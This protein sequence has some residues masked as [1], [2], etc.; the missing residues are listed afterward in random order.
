MSIPP[1]ALHLPHLKPL[2]S[3]WQFQ[4]GQP[5]GGAH[6]RWAGREAANHFYGLAPMDE[7]F[8]LAFPGLTATKVDATGFEYYKSTLK[9]VP[10]GPGVLE[11]E[12]YKPLQLALSAICRG[13]RGEGSLE[14]SIGADNMINFLDEGLKLSPD[15]IFHTTYTRS[16]PS[17][18]YG[19]S[20][21]EV[22][23]DEN[24]DPLHLT[25]R[26]AS[27]RNVDVWNQ[28]TE[29][30]GI[31]QKMTSRCFY[32]AAGV[33]GEKARFFLWDRSGV[34]AS[35]S[36]KYKSNP[37]PL[38]KFL[39]G[40]ANYRTGGLDATALHQLDTT[41]A[42]N[43]CM[44]W[45][46]I[47]E[48]GLLKGRDYPAATLS[49]DLPSESSIVLV[50]G[51]D[52]SKQER[53]LTIGRPVFASESNFGRGTRVWLAIRAE[54]PTDE[55]VII[56]DGWRD[57]GRWS[58][59]RIYDYI[60]KKLGEIPGIARHKNGFDVDEQG[61][62]HRTLAHRLVDAL[63]IGPSQH[64]IHHRCIL[65]SVGKPL[66]SFSSTYQ[67]L[68]AIRDVVK[69]LHDLAKLGILHR[70]IS[71]NNIMISIDPV[72]ENGAKG[73]VID[74]ELA[75]IPEMSKK[76]L[77]YLTGTIQFLSIERLQEN[78]SDHKSWHDLE[79]VFWTVLWTVL[80]H[81]NSWVTITEYGTPRPG[82]DCVTEIFD[83]PKGG[84]KMI[85]LTLGKVEVQAA[86]SVYTKYIRD[87]EI[88]A[89]LRQEA[90]KE[91]KDRLSHESF[92]KAI[93]DALEDRS[94]WPSN[95]GAKNFKPAGR[96][97]TEDNTETGI[98]LSQRASWYTSSRDRTRP[99]SIDPPRSMGMS[100]IGSGS[101][102]GSGMVLRYDT[103]TSENKQ[104]SSRY[105]GSASRLTALQAVEENA[106]GEPR[107]RAGPVTQMLGVVHPGPGPGESSQETVSQSKSK[108]PAKA[109][110]V[111][112]AT[113]SGSVS[114][115]P[116]SKQTLKKGQLSTSPQHRKPSKQSKHLA[117][118]TPD[119]PLRKA[120]A[121]TKLGH[122]RP[123]EGETRVR[124][125]SEVGTTKKGA[126]SSKALHVPENTAKAK[127][128]GV[129]TRREKREE[130][131]DTGT[132]SRQLRS[133]E[134]LRNG[135]S[136][137][138]TGRSS[139]STKPSWK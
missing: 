27:L 22:K 128:G 29:Y 59:T 97:R 16:L 126:S 124:H 54:G 136:M 23:R 120:G 131:L 10:V 107:I 36:F 90:E 45:R 109:S 61:Y 25:D 79:S 134:A 18:A 92:L 46:K 49:T 39:D 52:S 103:H 28:I 132:S 57:A 37:A 94:Q 42:S 9:G 77:K 116:T 70:D 133:K 63:N 71:A 32:V 7:F 33:F 58:E 62:P 8:D 31:A 102:P 72:K 68:E 21:I 119:S 43:V 85:F 4:S 130:E 82:K 118:K 89:L 69:G 6:R 53:Y 129:W 96:P 35:E 108:L 26:K 5:E 65:N 56:K 19:I 91:L 80:R 135:E 87:P 40:L 83:T 74:P 99:V 41:E 113:A 12:M 127:A 112:P 50:P 2:S 66:S 38:V 115:V 11:K 105:T 125:S 44:A 137:C 75:F 51:S 98:T 13:V 84:G 138:D 93:E 78:Q 88:K 34:L 111:A 14:P 81:T 73:F 121:D 101:G 106:P 17:W 122:T 47:Q 114:S 67:L 76:E 110:A 20:F 30:A 60:R 24:D 104:S 48:L 100:G 86:I 123:P 117:S 55:F 95:D 15:I 3:R 1:S 139:G 64:R